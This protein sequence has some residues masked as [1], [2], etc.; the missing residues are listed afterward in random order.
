MHKILYRG[1]SDEE[2]HLL[3]STI[4]RLYLDISE[5]DRYERELLDS[6]KKLPFNKNLIKYKL[7]HVNED[8]FYLSLGRHI[9][10]N[11]RLLDWTSS[12]DVAEYFAS[13]NPL[14]MNKTGCVWKMEIPDDYFNR[15]HYEQISPFELPDIINVV[16]MDYWGDSVSEFPEPIRRRFTQ[17]GFFSISKLEYIN[18]PINEMELGEIKISKYKEISPCN[19]R[20]NLKRLKEIRDRI[21]LTNEEVEVLLLNNKYKTNKDYGKEND[22]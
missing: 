10:L 15:T 4:G 16:K 8:M 2:N 9:G 12:I 14:D 3:L 20:G 18:T 1:V 11:C 6:Y 13:C 5:I 21:L 22:L 17:N 19:K 7:N